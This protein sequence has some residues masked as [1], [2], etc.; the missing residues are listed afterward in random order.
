MNTFTLDPPKSALILVDLQNIVVGRTL[1]PYTGADVVIRGAILGTAFR[2]KGATVVYI[3][4]DMSNF[5]NPIT[6]S[7]G[8]DPNAP[9]PPPN[10]L[11]IALG[12]GFQEGDLHVTKRYWGSF[13]GTDLEA[14]LRSRGVDTVAIGG[15]ATNYGVESTAR[16]AAGLGFNVVL[17][18]DAMTS[19]SAEM[20]QFP[21][22]SI[23]PRLGRVRSSEQVIAA[24]G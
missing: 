21:V 8:R 16:E 12:A 9:A 13:I 14:Q 15:I 10:A 4:V 23:F 1:A 5:L 19:L 17:V 2:E 18:E 3:T 11:E 6:D 24:L 7:P 20:H 22:T